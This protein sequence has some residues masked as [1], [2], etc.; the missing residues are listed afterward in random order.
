MTQDHSNGPNGYHDEAWLKTFVHDDGW[1][2]GVTYGVEKLKTGWRVYSHVASIPTSKFHDKIY[3]DPTRI[4]ATLRK[5]RVAEIR[6]AREDHLARREASEA[7][8]QKIEKIWGARPSVRFDIGKSVFFFED[9]A[10]EGPLKGRKFLIHTLTDKF[11]VLR[12]TFKGSLSYTDVQKGNLK[13]FLLKYIDDL[14]TQVDG[15]IA[16]EAKAQIKQEPPQVNQGPPRG[17]VKG[18]A[19]E[20]L[21]PLYEGLRS[22]GAVVGYNPV[23]ANKEGPTGG[24]LDADVETWINDDGWSMGLV[25]NVREGMSQWK[26]RVHP[27]NFPYEPLYE[28]ATDDPTKIIASLLKQRLDDLKLTQ[29]LRQERKE[30]VQNAVQKIEKIWGVR[31]SVKS[32]RKRDDIVF[33]GDFKAPL[34]DQFYIIQNFDIPYNSMVIDPQFKV[35]RPNLTGGPLTYVRSQAGNLS[36]NL[37]KHIDE[38]KDQMIEL[39]GT[40]GLAAPRSKQESPQGNQEPPDLPAILRRLG[41]AYLEK[42]AFAGDRFFEWYLDPTHSE[43]LSNYDWDEDEWREQYANPMEEKI[44]NLL[45]QVFERRGLFSIEIEDKGFATI[46]TTPTGTRYFKEEWKP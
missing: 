25:Y 33:D 32:S 34:K 8:A 5:Q 7:A 16:E 2:N 23:Y 21:M 30:A 44:E 4:L 39:L 24:A 37:L 15:L 26:V 40:E 19:R 14:K 27:Y 41:K 20:F 29:K 11:Q 22:Y 1:T 42:N 13:D 38:V 46:V 12:P 31:P 3:T 17:K 45:F 10:F 28:E 9:D 6:A 18:S 35:I 43:K 36:D